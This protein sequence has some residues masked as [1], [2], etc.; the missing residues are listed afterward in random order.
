MLHYGLIVGAHLTLVQQPTTVAVRDAILREYDASSPNSV[1]ATCSTCFHKLAAEGL[2]A[3]TPQQPDIRRRQNRTARVAPDPVDRVAS[4]R[5]TTSAITSA[6][7]GSKNKV[8]VTRRPPHMWWT[9]GVESMTIRTSFAGVEE[10]PVREMFW[11]VLTHVAD[12]HGR[13]AIRKHV[14]KII[15]VIQYSA[16]LFTSN[17]PA[18]CCSRNH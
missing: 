4:W 3:I 13:Q 15:E 7:A 11:V 8:L 5:I 14:R 1:N 10:R 16:S 9:D 6:Q 18:L 12:G 17:R 2:I